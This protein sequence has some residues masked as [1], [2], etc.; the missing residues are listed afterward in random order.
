M[1]LLASDERIEIV[2][3]AEDG[4]AAVDLAGSLRPDIILMDVSMPH[5]NGVEATRRIK[6]ELPGTAV[7]M[8]TASR[9]HEDVKGAA[10]AGAAGYLTKDSASSDLITTILEIAALASALP[11][12]PHAPHA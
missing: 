8:L 3:H 6:E 2:G 5:L 7:L 10:A 11:S 1:N 9:S 4:R 12:G